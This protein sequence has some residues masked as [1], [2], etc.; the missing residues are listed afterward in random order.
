VLPP[1]DAGAVKETFA[2]ALPAVAVTEVGEPGVPDGVT[3]VDA[4]DAGLFP[5]ALVATTVKV[6]AVPLVR[7]GMLIGLAVPVAVMLPGLELTVYPVI[8][9]PPF[10]AETVKETFAWVLPAVADT[11]VGE[12]GTPIGVTEFDAVD[13]GLLP[14]TL[15]AT[16]V[17]V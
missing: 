14:T 15:V 5:A 6:Y 11:E 17:K 2:W 1:F 12:P 16:V 3:E 10:D 9:L 4:A 7:P 13:A 8:A